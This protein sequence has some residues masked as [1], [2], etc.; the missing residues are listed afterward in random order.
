[1]TRW[2]RWLEPPANEM[3]NIRPVYERVI[4]RPSFTRAMA[5]EGVKAFG[6]T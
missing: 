4:A 5:R 2:G 3:R 6:T 1:M